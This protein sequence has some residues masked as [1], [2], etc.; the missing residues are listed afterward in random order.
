MNRFINYIIQRLRIVWSILFLINCTCILGQS[1][2]EID[3]DKEDQLYYLPCMINGLEYSM[4]FDT[5][6]NRTVINKA[7]YN[8]LYNQGKISLN[9]FIGKTEMD[10]AIGISSNV[11]CVKLKEI[12]IGNIKLHDI[13]AVVLPN[14][15]IPP[16]LGQNAINHMG[17]IQ[18][19]N[20]KLCIFPQEK[21][22]TEK[23]ENIRSFNQRIKQYGIRSYGSFKSN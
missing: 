11:P 15:N 10:N 2:V 19:C 17:K 5:G 22:D 3:L 7:I 9:D 16:I 23:R 6:A 20:K 8:E 4:I 12:I 1:I 13:E 18:I 14:E 21:E